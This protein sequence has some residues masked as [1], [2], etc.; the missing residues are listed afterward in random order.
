VHGLNLPTDRAAVC[1]ACNI[2][3]HSNGFSPPPDRL[4]QG[5]DVVV[6]LVGGG[7][8]Y[9]STVIPDSTPSRATVWYRGYLNYGVEARAGML[10]GY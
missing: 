7:V 9:V 10:S 4:T 6:R 2:E 8:I 5:R 1:M 3:S